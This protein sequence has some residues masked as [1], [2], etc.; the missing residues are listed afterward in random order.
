MTSAEKPK[1]FFI[2]V[3]ICDVTHQERLF[4]AVNHKV[5][6]ATIRESQLMLIV[7]RQLSDVLL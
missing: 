5:P 6:N 7:K 1:L 4:V 3:C 2:G